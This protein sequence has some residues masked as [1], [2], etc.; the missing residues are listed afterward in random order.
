MILWLS[1]KKRLSSLPVLYIR[2]GN[3]GMAIELSDVLCVEGEAPEM[4]QETQRLVIVI[5][6]LCEGL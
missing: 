5:Y 1:S 3:S 4:L 2:T 6:G